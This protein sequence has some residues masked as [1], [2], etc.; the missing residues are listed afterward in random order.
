[1]EYRKLHMEFKWAKPIVSLQIPT[2]YLIYTRFKE[3]Q[4][5]TELF[6]DMPI[7]LTKYAFSFTEFTEYSH[8]IPK[9]VLC[10]FGFTYI[11][12]PE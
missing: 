2:I 12:Y 3:I 8:Y 1:M 6:H 9:A 7:H 5:C 10:G 11:S 4:S